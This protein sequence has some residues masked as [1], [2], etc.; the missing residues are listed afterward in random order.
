[1]I[2]SFSWKKVGTAIS[3]ALILPFALMHMWDMLDFLRGHG[4]FLAYI[5]SSFLFNA[6]AIM[7][8][9]TTMMV[10]YM[11]MLIGSKIKRDELGAGLIMGAAL[12]IAW[13]CYAGQHDA[14]QQD[15]AIFGS[16]ITLVGISLG[17]K[18]VEEK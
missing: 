4:H 17:L 8:F 18:G 9:G 11:L 7:K 14:L 3:I 16:L 12:F 15:I 5:K 13:F 1:M 6:F 2:S 10:V